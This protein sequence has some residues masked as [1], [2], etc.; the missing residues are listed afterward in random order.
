M[1]G[2]ATIDDIVINLTA[3]SKSAQSKVDDLVKALDKIKTAFKDF[4]IDT[5][6]LWKISDA[7]RQIQ[8]GV[9]PDAGKKISGVATAIGRLGKSAS[10]VP[11]DAGKNIKSIFDVISGV[12]EGAI[13][14]LKTFIDTFASLKSIGK[15]GEYFRASSV[16]FNNLIAITRQIQDSDIQKLNNFFTAMQG[17]RVERGSSAVISKTFV[18]NLERFTGI[19]RKLSEDDIKKTGDLMDHLKGVNVSAS[20]FS[21]VKETISGL[22]K[23]LKTSDTKELDRKTESVNSKVGD[24]AKKLFGLGSSGSKN[25]NI[26]TK[27]FNSLGSAIGKAA[28]KIK[29]L[30]G[31]KLKE[32][33]V[34]PINSIKNI[35]K[36]FNTFFHQLRRIAVYRLIRSA[37]KAISQGLKEGVEN[38]YRFSEIYGTQFKPDM[39]SI[40]TSLLYMK[41]SLATVAEPI[42]HVLEPI[43]YKVSE[44]FAQITD[45]VAEFLAAL[46]GENQYTSAL[47]YFHE[48]EE[49]ARA[50]AKELQKWLGPF[51][52]INRL[53]ADNRSGS[54]EELLDPSKMFET[55][56]IDFSVKQFAER[57]KQLFKDEDFEGIG[58]FIGESIFSKILSFDFK[59]AGGGVDKFFNGILDAL[60]GFEGTIEWDKLGEKI[61]E[62]ITAIR[63]GDIFGKIT[64]L[65]INVF[66]GLLSALASASSTIIDDGVIEDVAK[67]IGEAIA[68]A[69]WKKIFSDIGTLGLNII[70]GIGQ[71]IS[72]ALQGLFDLDED[73]ADTLTE[74]LGIGALA[75]AIGNVIGK[76]TGSG[77]LLSAF[78]KK[79]T[80]LKKQSKLMQTETAYAYDMSHAF[81]TVAG[82]GLVALISKLGEFFPALQP[83]LNLLGETPPAVDPVATSFE[84]LYGEIADCD[85]VLYEYS[86][87]TTPK[88]ETAIKDIGA[89]VGQQGEA[90]GLAGTAAVGAATTIFGW[91]LKTSTQANL[92]AETYRKG[93]D[94]IRDTYKGVDTTIENTTKKTNTFGEKVKGVLEDVGKLGVALGGAAAMG[95]ALGAALGNSGGTPAKLYE[96][97]IDDIPRRASGGFVGTGQLFLA[98]ESG[99]ELVGSMNGR[100]AVANNDQIVAG[101]SRG[102]ENANENVVTAIYSA[103]SQLIQRMQSGGGGMSLASLAKAVTVQQNRMA[104]ASNT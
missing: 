56:N 39:D 24:V 25:V 70:K 34:S 99:P 50:T 72:G 45:R 35:S 5:G 26:L 89:A 94:E 68:N 32:W 77:G 79:D 31:A 29:S 8:F 96:R 30:V 66:T 104:V 57:I 48:Y 51:D 86:S 19:I 97:A 27:A 42:I 65:K 1:P 101:I 62:F 81:E 15:G 40:A 64:T 80:G 52:E 73:Q 87:T 88:A 10:S 13:T 20:A 63:W 16:G 33:L 9:S 7:F 4:N 90:W 92:T 14:T 76:I 60:V 82:V 43:L 47:R 75:I 46:A 28:S 55:V 17:S 100:T 53:N 18:D 49:S 44:M 23:A 95:L 38:L 2:S 78:K 6:H 11:Q 85:R 98:R 83:T 37:L 93:L 58:E 74:I 103:T 102:V 41:N 3:S 36:G 59:S 12:R 21:G 22:N 61:G 91:L 67:K 69:D 84:N 71:A 54:A